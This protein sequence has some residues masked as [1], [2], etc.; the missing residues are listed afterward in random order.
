[1]TPSD[2][3]NNGK[4]IIIADDFAMSQGTDSAILELMSQGKVHFTS[5]LVTSSRFKSVT[6]TDF[7]H[8]RVGLHLDFTFGKAI[9]IRGKSML[10]DES[11]NFKRSFMQIM[12][13]CIFRKK[14]MQ[15][16]V[17]CEIEAQILKLKEK[18]PNISHID[19]HQHT[20]MN[21]LI[22]AEVQ[23]LA[24]K[25]F[26]P[27]VRIINEKI[28]Q[29]KS[30]HPT[31]CVNFAKL[32]LLRTLA[33]F[34][35]IKPDFKS[36]TYFVSILHTCKISKDILQKY[37]IPKKFDTIE[38]MLHPSDSSPDADLNKEKKHLLSK[39]RLIEKN[40]LEN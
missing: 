29:L 7:L 39:F 2:Y 37:Q 40:S 4:A 19:G 1:M 13:L 26:I 22:F 36:K 16:L 33:F 11:G 31:N 27:R 15:K 10:T 24:K 12:F 32:L 20:H 3:I 14:T 9:S 18:F 17:A 34:C 30:F 38:I 25:Y 23:T 8:D 6:V 28:F 5:A 35:D 21:P